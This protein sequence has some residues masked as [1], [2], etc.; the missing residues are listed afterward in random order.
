VH[1][2]KKHPMV[3]T[4]NW[5]GDKESGEIYCLIP[6][7]SGDE[8]SRGWWDNVDPEEIMRSEHMVQ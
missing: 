5:Y 8:R 6:P 2:L 1:V 4:V 7:G 3:R